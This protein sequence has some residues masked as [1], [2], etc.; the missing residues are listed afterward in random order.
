MLPDKGLVLARRSRW[1][2][3]SHPNLTSCPHNGSKTG[4]WRLAVC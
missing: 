3:Y 2:T 1:E 4:L